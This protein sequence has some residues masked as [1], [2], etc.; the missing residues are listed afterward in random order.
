LKP[1]LPSFSLLFG[2]KRRGRSGV[3]P[4][5]ATTILLGITV[6]LGLALWSFANAGVGTATQQYAETVTDYGNFASDRFVIANIDFDN[7]STGDVAFW[8]YNSGKFPTTINNVVLTCRDCSAAFDP[9]PTII[10]DTLTQVP[11]VYDDDNPLVM[12]T[13][14]L[15]KFYF[16]TATNIE[17]QMTYDLTVVSETGA[18][19]SYVK[20]SD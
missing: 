3:S 10:S 15:K 20:R 19:Q 8:I 16:D 9:D 4:V 17:A 18:S 11:P 13:K 6:T 1:P 7:P 2:R 12:D 14:T 5:I